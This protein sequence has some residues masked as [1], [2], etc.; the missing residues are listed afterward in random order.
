MVRFSRTNVSVGKEVVM[1]CIYSNFDG[2]CTLS[3]SSDPKDSQ[4]QGCGELDESED[5]YSCN[6]EDDPVPSDNCESYE[7]DSGC[8]ECG[9]DY[10]A[11]EECE[12]Q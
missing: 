2:F 12:C 10:N 4:P 11:D 3:S 1:G 7:T 5:M 9:A 6:V 8:N